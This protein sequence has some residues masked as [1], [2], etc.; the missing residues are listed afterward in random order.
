MDYAERQ[1]EAAKIREE[2]KE[3]VVALGDHAATPPGK[4]L[5]RRFIAD[6]AVRLQQSLADADAVAR[7]AAA[8]VLRDGVRYAAQ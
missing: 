7:H 5:V 1:A 6:Q 3:F 4:M 2:I 8:D